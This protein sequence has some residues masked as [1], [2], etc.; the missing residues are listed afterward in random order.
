[1]GVG[2]SLEIPYVLPGPL[3][4]GAYQLDV[5]SHSAPS[6]PTLHAEVLW[7]A[8]GAPESIDQA[9]VAADSNSANGDI[10]AQPSG[11]AVAAA[12]GDQLVL[13]VKYVASA[14]PPADGGASGV[15]DVG[16]TVG[17]P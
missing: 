17:I 12:C 2:D 5:V 6:P 10:H 9:I 3:P 16:A 8:A 11:A 1:M 7:R 13:R 15:I 14:T 4:A